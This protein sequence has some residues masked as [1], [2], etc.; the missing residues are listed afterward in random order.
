MGGTLRFRYGL[1]FALLLTSLSIV[2]FSLA[3]QA[4][5]D[6][7]SAPE[8][9]DTASSPAT[10]IELPGQRT[11]TSDTFKLENGALEKRVYGG[12]VNYKDGEGDWK[13]IDE[14]LEP[15]PRGGFTNGANSFD[16]QLPEKIG[17]GAVRLSD[18]GEWLSYKLLGPTTGAAEVD[19]A[20]ASYDGGNGSSFE[21][22]SLGNGVKE[23]IQLNSPVAPRLYRFEL[24]LSHGLSPALE[25]DG[26]IAVDDEQGNLFATLPAPTISDASGA[27]PVDAVHY[28]LEEDPEAGRWT[29]SVEA[30][31]AWVSDPERSWPVTIDPSAFIF[32]ELDCT[33]GSTPLPAG[34]SVCGSSGATEL[35]T[36]Y[37][38]IEKEPVRTFLRFNLGGVVNPVIP[39][40]DY[41]KKAVIKLYAPKA[42][43]NTTPGLETDRVIKNWNTP[44]NWERWTSFYNWTTPGGDFTSEGHAEVLT[45]TRPGGSGAGWWEFTSSSLLE[46]VRGC[47]TIRFLKP[48]SPTRESSLSK[49]TRP[50]PRNAKVAVSVLVATSASIRVRHLRTSPSSISSITRRRHQPTR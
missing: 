50:G 29:L 26:S 32:T 37:S 22:H 19:G 5:S 46:L 38:Q 25:H 13:P 36:A 33:I 45:A 15:A 6:E 7:A 20:A 3:P 44:L 14:E 1:L 49:L 34:W 40:K 21:M 47:S 9:P 28:G 2:A 48:G 4:K 41:V 11:A 31:E 30:D 8:P 35:I 39:P 27:P 23:E 24:K 16:L 43:E 12:R 10:A 17:E 18:E 42:A